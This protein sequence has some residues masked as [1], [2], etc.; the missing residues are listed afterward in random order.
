MYQKY[1]ILVILTV[2]AGLFVFDTGADRRALPGPDATQTPVYSQVYDPARDPFA[3]GKAALALARMT[4]KRVLIEVGGEWCS[5]CH[6]I[7]RFLKEHPDVYAAL[8]ANFVVL[9][10]NVSDENDNHEFMAGLPKPLGY[11]HFYITE[12]DGSIIQSQDTAELLEDGHYS[13]V[14]FMSFVKRWGIDD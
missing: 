2:I 14:R 5:W 10:F 4:D 6:V 11:P 3:D 13:R 9:K 8:Q 1:S 12:N 7:A